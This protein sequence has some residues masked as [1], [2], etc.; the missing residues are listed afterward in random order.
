MDIISNLVLQLTHACNCDFPMEYVADPILKCEVDGYAIF[1]ARVISTAENNS[2]DFLKLLQAWASEEPSMVVNLVEIKLVMV[3]S[4]PV[5]GIGK[6]ECTAPTTTGLP[7]TTMTTEDSLAV[8]VAP[9]TI[10]PVLIALIIVVIISTLCYYVYFRRPGDQGQNQDQNQPP[11][12]RLEDQDQDQDQ[13]QDQ[14]QNQQRNDI[15]N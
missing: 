7:N 3:C 8:I 5:N 11:Y 15:Y 10:L 13:G 1:Q 4:V 14:D 2:T 6:T 9:V 12:R